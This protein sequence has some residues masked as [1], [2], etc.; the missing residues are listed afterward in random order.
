MK[1]MFMA[2]TCAATLFAAGSASA[3]SYT[4]T[5]GS[6]YYDLG[7]GL[8]V[9]VYAYTYTSEDPLVL[10]AAYLNF[11]NSNG[12]GIGNGSSQDP[13]DSKDEEMLVFVFNQAVTVT[14]L[15]LNQ[16]DKNDHIDL[17][18]DNS[19]FADD[20]DGETV[21][22]VL[23]SYLATYTMFGIGTNYTKD[24]KDSQDQFRVAGITYSW[25]GDNNTGDPG[26]VPLPATG[27]L[28]LGGLGGLAALRKRRKSA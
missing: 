5:D 16:I 1:A 4:F 14:G 26:V 9:N 12:F 3:A 25:D 17:V 20:I 6:G 28:L 7:G 11:N 15:D 13:I 22:D 18:A 24:G 19:L 8:T 27:L 21:N 23:S 2:A 10:E